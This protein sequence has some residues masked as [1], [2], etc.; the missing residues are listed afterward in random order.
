VKRSSRTWLWVLVVLLLIAAAGGG[1]LLGKG[2]GT[3][4]AGSPTST[5]PPPSS[6]PSSSPSP[7]AADLKDGK[8]FIYAKKTGDGPTL[9]FD[10]ALFLTG[11]AAIDAATAHGDESPP[12][13][14]YYIVNDDHKLRTYPVS[15]TVVVRFIPPL[16]G[17]SLKKGSFDGWA[18]AVNGTAMTDY[19]GKSA[20]WW[21]T[22][23][24]GQIVKIVQQYQP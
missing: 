20:S 4:A 5:T 10:L 14:D 13:N 22:I 16:A 12:P 24:G 1:F 17:N 3:T 7:V 9:T 15:A 2:K 21:I 19:P 11:K 6:T 18:A 23:S 8:Y